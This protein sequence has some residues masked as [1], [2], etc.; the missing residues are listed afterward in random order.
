MQLMLNTNCSH[1]KGVSR[2]YSGG[3]V[4]PLSM[5]VARKPARGFLRG[6][7]KTGWWTGPLLQGVPISE[8][9]IIYLFCHHVLF[10]P[11][12]YYFCKNSKSWES[13]TPQ[14]YPWFL[15]FFQFFYEF[16]G[17]FLNSMTFPVIY[18]LCIKSRK[19]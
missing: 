16:L 9:A 7:D 15:K 10:L 3:G 13:I 14:S 17:S 1:S 11:V 5:C 4:E 6:S 19:L 8:I 12:Y 2:I 18:K